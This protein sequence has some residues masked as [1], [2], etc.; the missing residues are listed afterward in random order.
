[1]AP[2]RSLQRVKALLAEASTRLTPLIILPAL[3]AAMLFAYP[4][5]AADLPDTVARIKPSVVGVGTF[6]KTRNP[7]AVFGGTGFVIAD[8]LH[9]VTNAHV[10]P[11]ELDAQRREQLIVLAR[12]GDAI[13]QRNAEVRALAKESDLAV[14]R[15]DGPPLPALQIG[16][17][18][19]LREGQALAFTGFPIGMVLGLHP[20]TH[21]AT[22][23]A[24][25]PVARPGITA[26]Q[27][28]ARQITRIRDEAYVVFQLDGTAYPGNSGSP[29]YDPGTGEVYGII[30]SVFIQGTREMAVSRPSGITYAIPS[31]NLL[32]VLRRE[33]VPGFQ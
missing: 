2:H 15:I 3:F 17:S 1:M 10:L 13:E 9:V 26:R 24:I 23:A 28:N 33:N 19:T 32:E 11:R 7:S 6:L 8:G 18:S 22:L 20:A 4:S 14:L 5:A 27:L 21:R 30:N 29:L 16:N 12:V 31:R 25:T